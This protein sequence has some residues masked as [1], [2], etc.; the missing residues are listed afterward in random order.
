MSG[1]NRVLAESESMG[2]LE[3]QVAVITGGANG[4]GR[5]TALRFLAEG[6]RVVIADVNDRNAAAVLDAAAGLGH[7]GA[8]RFARAD[9][10][11]EPDV[12]A[13]VRCAV[14]AFG[15]LDCVFNNAG[16]GGAF[17]PITETRVE[18]WDHT[19]AV[20]LRGV[21]LG[22]KHG[23]RALRA[24]GQGGAIV[25]TAS[26]AGFCAGGGAHC[27]SAAKAAIINL[28]R[29]VS[30]ELAP[31]RIRVNAVAPGPLMTDL[32]HRG[33]PEAAERA[34]LERQ[35][36]PEA[37]RPEDVAAA[38]VFLASAEAAFINGETVVID[39][40]LLA[41]GPAVFG[42]GPDS[43]LLRAAGL[44]RGSTGEPSEVRRL[45]R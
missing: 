20:L 3:G 27:Y 22:I 44:D 39:G 33:H 1:Y 37:G 36:W 40:G 11:Q 17:G 32:F 26:V 16:I 15:R 14:E 23:A 24:Q 42:S 19:V 7:A 41:R 28:T 8:I 2:R 4:I 13:A 30:T 29:S 35:P 25:S 10:S 31:Y 21:F 18:E 34:I 6:A 12:E 45:E 43:L 5:A 38:V 9:V